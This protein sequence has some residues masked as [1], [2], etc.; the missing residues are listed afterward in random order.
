M[1]FPVLTL[2]YIN[3]TFSEY[4]VSKET[5]DFQTHLIHFFRHTLVKIPTQDLN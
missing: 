1:W 3:I 5:E 2:K 4:C